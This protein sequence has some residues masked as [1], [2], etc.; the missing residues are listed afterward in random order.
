[1]LAGL[2]KA[3]GGGEFKIPYMPND[4][5]GFTD[6]DIPGYPGKLVLQ[7]VNGSLSPVPTAAGGALDNIAAA[8]PYQNMG[9]PGAKSYHLAAE[10]YGNAAYVSLG[11]ANPYFSR[12]ASSGTTSVVKDAVAQNP[13]F[14]SLWIGNNDVL[15]YA[16]S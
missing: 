6:T 5:G 2:M 13:T 10:G 3:A 7:I 12:F 15:S 16:T 9:V 4:T 1:M 14:F 8:G 11:K